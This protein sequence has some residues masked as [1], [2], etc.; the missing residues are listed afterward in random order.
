MKFAVITII[1]SAFLV[2]NAVI[3][4][5]LHYPVGEKTRGDWKKDL[6]KRMSIVLENLEEFYRDIKRLSSPNGSSQKSNMRGRL[7]IDLRKLRDM[8]RPDNQSTLKDRE[9]TFGEI[10]DTWMKFEVLEARFERWTCEE[11]GP[12]YH[13]AFCIPSKN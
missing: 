2:V 3:P 10:C 9:E 8:L 1:V 13:L 6:N 11:N 7:N 4:P 5:P 12:Y